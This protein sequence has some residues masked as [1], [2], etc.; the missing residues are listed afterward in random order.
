MFFFK[1]RIHESV[2]IAAIL[3]AAISLHGLWIANLLITRIPA[4]SGFFCGSGEG[5]AVPSLYLFG[6]LLFFI[7]WCVLTLIFRGRDCSHHRENAFWFLMVSTI[8]FLFMTLPII[9]GFVS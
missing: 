3:A 5:G 1:P 4:V 9:F 7:A 8:I 2:A 6:L